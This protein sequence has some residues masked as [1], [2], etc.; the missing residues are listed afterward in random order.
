MKPLLNSLSLWSGAI[1]LLI[2]L[3]GAVAFTF[4]DIMGDRLYGSKRIGFTLMLYAYA[5]Y[6]GFRIYQTLKQN[7]HAEE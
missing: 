6:R 2:V 1:T 4:T 5:I 7:K 3:S